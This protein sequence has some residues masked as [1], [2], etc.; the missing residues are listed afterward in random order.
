MLGPVQ[1][2]FTYDTVQKL[3]SYK[4]DSVGVQEV[5]W[6]KGGTVRA[7][8]YCFLLRKKKRKSEVNAGKTKYMVMSRVQ[9]TGRSHSI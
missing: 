8:D 7:R 1:V 6:D 5:R 9:N 3:A 2:S 4:L